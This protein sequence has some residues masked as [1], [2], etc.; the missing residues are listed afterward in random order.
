MRARSSNRGHKQKIVKIMSNQVR[1]R[2]PF[3]VKLEERAKFFKQRAGDRAAHGHALVV[4]K[5]PF[6][7]KPQQ[8]IKLSFKAI[9]NGNIL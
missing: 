3:D 1:T 5:F 6:K 7:G 4:I 8:F 2:E 9:Y